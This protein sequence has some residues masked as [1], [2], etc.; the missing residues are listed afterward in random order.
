MSAR[1]SLAVRGALGAVLSRVGT[2]PVSLA[3]LALAAAY[4]AAWAWARGSSPEAAHALATSFAF[5]AFAAALAIDAGWGLLRVVP[6]RVT[7]EGKVAFTGRAALG[8]LLVRAGHLLVALAFA[9]SLLSRDRLELRVAVGEE[10][11]GAPGQFVERDPPRRMSPGPFPIA[12][13][14]EAAEVRF[15]AGGP[16]SGPSATLLLPDGERAHVGRAWPLWSG[17]GRFLLAG[18]AG[19][20][21]RYEIADGTGREVDSAFTRLDLFP[22]G[23]ADSIRPMGVPHRI[24][25]A[26]AGAPAAPAPAP[27]ALR[28]AA[29]R[30]KLLVAEGEVPPGGALELEGLVLR[31]PEARPWVGFAMV[32]DPGVPIALLGAAVAAAGFA[33][34]ALAKRRR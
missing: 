14:L 25:V 15:G 6:L 24:Y 17:F 11:S 2:P 23:K 29:Y 9:A 33:L 26:L 5:E 10:F 32:R 20:A 21:L 22:A 13:A 8:P 7:A 1:L 19:L 4:L 18:G 30:G 27:P 31:F 34:A 16:V 12:F 3:L 28:V